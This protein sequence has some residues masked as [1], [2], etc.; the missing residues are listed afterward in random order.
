[1]SDG[2][3]EAWRID[4]LKERDART[5]GT[6]RGDEEIWKSKHPRNARSSLSTLIL[7]RVCLLCGRLMSTPPGRI[8]RERYLQKFLS[9]ATVV[10]TF[11]SSNHMTEK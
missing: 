7:I 6:M 4:E 8:E 3:G 2:C 11:Q 9:D 10:T 1:M 5:T